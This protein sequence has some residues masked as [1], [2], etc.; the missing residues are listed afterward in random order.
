[1]IPLTIKSMV[2]AAAA[3]AAVSA[4]TTCSAART[5]YGAKADVAVAAAKA[6]ADKDVRAALAERD[7]IVEAARQREEMVQAEVTEAVARA[8]AQHYKEMQHAQDEISRLRAGVATGAVRLR[9]HQADSHS[10]HDTPAASPRVDNHTGAVAGTGAT[11]IERDILD[12]GEYAV[13]AI[14]QRDACVDILKAE[15][16]I[17]GGAAHD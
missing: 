6:S 2:L 8:D 10:C 17:T 12:L 1:M 4:L 14:K 5:Y 9:Q 3:A 16:A 13:T 15:R 11:Q 7:A